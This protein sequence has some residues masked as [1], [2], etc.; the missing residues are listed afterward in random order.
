RIHRGEIQFSYLRR[1]N[2]EV[3][4]RTTSLEDAARFH[5]GWAQ[6]LALEAGPGNAALLA[7]HQLRSNE[8]GRGVSLAI[9]A[10]EAHVVAG[11]FEAAAQLLEDACPQAKGELRSTILER[12]SELAS[13]RGKPREAVRYVEEWKA[14]LP[15]GQRSRALLRQAEL[16]N[17]AGDYDQ[18]LE[19]LED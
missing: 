19:L 1:S 7:H 4:A 15:A 14:E 3:A 12:L 10:A 2:Q 17:A 13:L 6:A 8:P 5:G 9:K 11:A 18:A 16:F